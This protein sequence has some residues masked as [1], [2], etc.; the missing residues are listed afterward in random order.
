MRERYTQTL[1]WQKGAALAGQ[2]VFLQLGVLLNEIA[3]LRPLLARMAQEFAEVSR[4][5]AIAQR[6]GWL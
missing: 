6:K 5:A 3:P 4:E 2:H 1:R